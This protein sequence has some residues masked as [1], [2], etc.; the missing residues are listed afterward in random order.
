MLTQE[1]DLQSEKEV[2]RDVLRLGLGDEKQRHQIENRDRK[3]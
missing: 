3:L 1:E 2:K